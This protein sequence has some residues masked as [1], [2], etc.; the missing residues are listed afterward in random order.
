[1]SARRTPAQVAGGGAEEAAARFLARRG[2][3]IVGR[4]FRTR[5]GEIDL[6]ARDGETLVFVEVRMRSSGR[7]GG[8]A[9]SVD[10]VKRSRIEAAARQYLA[11]LPREPACR[12]DVVSLEGDAPEWIRAAFECR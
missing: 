3:E 12:F 1:M 5:F 4:N 2:L 6:I 11:R 9:A 8:A 7:F 10:G